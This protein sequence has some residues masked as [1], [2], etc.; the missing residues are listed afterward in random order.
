MRAHTYKYATRRGIGA[1]RGKREREAPSKFW[2]IDPTFNRINEGRKRNFVDE[3]PIR[4]DKMPGF[5]GNMFTLLLLMF[6]SICKR[7]LTASI[8]KLNRKSLY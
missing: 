8:L 5:L 1:L 2:S 7:N 6:N 3:H 4:F